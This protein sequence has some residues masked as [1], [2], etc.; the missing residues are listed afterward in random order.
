MRIALALCLGSFALTIFIVAALTA[1]VWDTA[2]LVLIGGAAAL[3][4]GAAISAMLRPTSG[5]LQRNWGL[6]IGCAIG[7]A[8]AW[9]RALS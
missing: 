4:L 2:V 8:A 9:L 7:I 3:L 6:L 1:A 5:T